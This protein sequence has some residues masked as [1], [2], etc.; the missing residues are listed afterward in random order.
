MS[1]APR[2]LVVTLVTLGVALSACVPVP[3][4]WGKVTR[5]ADGALADSLRLGLDAAGA[6]VFAAM[7]TPP[8]LA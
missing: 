4:E 7:W 3:V 5:H 2:S 8:Q 6:P 1:S